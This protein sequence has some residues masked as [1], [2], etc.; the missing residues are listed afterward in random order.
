M[1][2]KNKGLAKELLKELFNIVSVA[3]VTE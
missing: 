1:K 2:L 3:G